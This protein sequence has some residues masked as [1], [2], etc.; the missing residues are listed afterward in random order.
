MKNFNELNALEAIK[1]YQSLDLTEEAE[2]IATANK[3][4][5]L[6]TVAW[7]FNREPRAWEHTS[8]AFGFIEESTMGNENL[9]ISEARNITADESLK[10]NQI[11]VSLDFLRAYDYP[12]KGKH[13]VLFKFN[14]LNHLQGNSQ[15]ISFNQTFAIQE[16]QRAPI[17]GYPIFIGLNT[18]QN[19]V[20][21]D[22]EIIN[23]SNDS[24]DKFLETMESGVVKNGMTLLNSINPIIPM[25][26]E[27]ATGITKMIANRNRNQQITAPKMGLYFGNIPTQMKL[28][29]GVYIAIQISNPGEFNWSV[30]KYNR[31]YG[32]IQSNDGQNKDLPYNYFIFS[33][34]KTN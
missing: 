16:G 2:A 4:S 24:D 27:Y 25:I 8:Y 26:T 33:V 6:E 34:S 11:T 28:A 20:Q 9:I 21:F 10:N 14:A 12:G 7:P 32:T 31:N 1:L 23:I 15:N 5:D 17:S 3:N 22:V 29:T 13:Q 18:G 19:L 30:W